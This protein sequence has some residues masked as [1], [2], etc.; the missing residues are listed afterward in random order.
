MTSDST[1]TPC[2]GD[3]ESAESASM[4]S[5]TEGNLEPMETV[6]SSKNLDSQ[7]DVE[8]DK[9]LPLK[10]PSEED[11]VMKESERKEDEDDHQLTLDD[12][13]LLCDLF[14]LPFEHG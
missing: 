12:L 4:V 3:A 6:E 7:L 1:L 11:V 13:F 10:E 9:E 5:V 2:L 8:E 14:Y